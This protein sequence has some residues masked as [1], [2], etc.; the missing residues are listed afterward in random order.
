M[1][2]EKHLSDFSNQPN[3]F[4]SQHVLLQPD[5]QLGAQSEVQLVSQHDGLGPEK[6]SVSTVLA[7]FVESKLVF[8]A[9]VFEE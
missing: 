1:N 6:N 8:I 5:E 4:E 7:L 3:N 2:L 9:D